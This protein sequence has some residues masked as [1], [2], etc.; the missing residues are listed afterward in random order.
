MNRS[1]SLSAWDS[2]ARVMNSK[3]RDRA[4]LSSLSARL[5]VLNQKYRFVQYFLKSL[6]EWLC[7]SEG[8]L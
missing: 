1:V 8:E 5:G 2:V 3:L 4:V 7:Q 6:R